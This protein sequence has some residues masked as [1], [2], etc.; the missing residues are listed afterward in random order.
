[1]ERNQ[2]G[3]LCKCG[4]KGERQKKH[5]KVKRLVTWKSFQSQLLGR[6]VKIIL[7]NKYQNQLN[8]RTVKYQ[9]QNELSEN[10]VGHKCHI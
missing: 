3:L 10:V 6:N 1:M 7:G 9:S 4:K 5:T 2:R 8:G